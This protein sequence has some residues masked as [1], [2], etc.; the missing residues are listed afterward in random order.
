MKAQDLELT[1]LRH[2]RS[3]ADDEQVHEGR[4][5]SPLTAL[6]IEQA[7]RLAA[8]WLAHPPGFGRLVSSPLSRARQT[9]E[10]LAGALKLEVEVSEDW[11]EFDNGPLAG[12]PFAEAERLYPKPSLRGRFE[13]LTAAGGESHA[14]FERRARQG[15]EG[16]MQGRH[17]NVLV[18]A[19]G[20]ILNMA[21]RDLLGAHRASF[22][23]GDTAFAQVTV[24]RNQDHATVR[25][26]NLQP[27]LQ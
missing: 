25:G 27:H 7:E 5:D 13:P 23:F 21:L 4:Y 9:A 15:L 6:G 19:H 12:L 2:G 8:W 11:L 18:V 17:A 16:V 10:I 22:T 26:V 14:S 20:G 1:L 24:A 3:R